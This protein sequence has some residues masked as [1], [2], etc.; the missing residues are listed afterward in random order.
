MM[1][2]LF[3]VLLFIFIFFL[4]YMIGKKDFFVPN[5]FAKISKKRVITK[6]WRFFYRSMRKKDVIA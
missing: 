1:S 5:L 6:K 4:I 3:F 2:R